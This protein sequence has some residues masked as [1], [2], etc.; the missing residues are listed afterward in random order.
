ML[1]SHRAAAHRIAALLR[2]ARCAVRTP[3]GVLAAAGAS[4]VLL[5][6]T[7]GGHAARTADNQRRAGGH[8][9][10]F[11]GAFLIK[12]LAASITLETG[13]SRGIV[14]RSF[15]V[16]ARGA[17]RYSS[18]PTAFLAAAWVSRDARRAAGCRA[19]A[20]AMELLPV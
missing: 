18:A 10:V 11:G 15:F 17:W 1:F 6:L 5:Y 9:A 14:T 12:I 7:A 2:K 20:M 16:G 4:L 3:A 19:A 8:T 13:G